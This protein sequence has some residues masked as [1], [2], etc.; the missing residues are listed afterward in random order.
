MAG[1]GLYEIKAY[2][3]IAKEPVF[4]GTGGYRIGRVDNTIVREPGTNLPKVPGTTIEGNARYYSWLHYKSVLNNQINIAC[5]KGKKTRDQ[6]DEESSPCGNCS[7]CIAYGYVNREGD[8]KSMA[9]LAHFSDAR[10]LFFPVSTMIGPVWITAPSILTDVLDQASNIELQSKKGFLVSKE[11][12]PFLP[13]INDTKKVLNFGWIMLEK[14]GVEGIED[15]DT[16]QSISSIFEK[17]KNRFC[18]V[19][20]DIFAQIVNSNLETRT[21]VSINPLTGTAES[22]ALFTYEAIPRGTVFWFE[23][24]YENPANYNL[25]SESLLTITHTVECGLNLF[26]SLGIGGM[27]TRGFGKMEILIEEKDER[28]FIQE[29]D[30]I[31]VSL[32]KEIDSLNKKIQDEEDLNKKSKLEIDQNI[33]KKKM[34]IWCK[35]LN[36]LK[37]ELHENISK[38]EEILKNLED[39]LSKCPE[40]G[41]S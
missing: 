21:S 9:G 31:L 22:G 37:E 39:V 12:D 38:K 25:Y 30:S 33:L 6:N 7:V 3:A 27:G 2:V 23:V 17:M 24:T 14:E 34:D 40:G 29:V 13:K 8:Q 35:Y 28:N 41:Q 5:A 10:I 1:G 19:P 20:D 11:L 26:S 18:I 16:W 36:H 15:Y 4:V 32:R